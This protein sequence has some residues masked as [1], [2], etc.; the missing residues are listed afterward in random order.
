MPPVDLPLTAEGIWWRY[1][2]GPWVLR[3]L[4]FTVAPGDLLRVRGGNGSGKS[5][6]LALL[7]GVVRPSRGS[8]RTPGRTAYLPQ[9][10][11]NLPPVP[12]D[13]VRALIGGRDGP[14][15]ES[16]AEHLGTRADQLS[17]GTARRVL[18]DAVLS[19]PAPVVVLDEPSAGLDDAAVGRLT[20][21]LAG[22]LADGGIVVVAEHRPLPLPGGTVLDLG[23]RSAAPAGALV[24]ITL[25]GDG[26]TRVVT[27]PPADRDALLRDALDRGWSVL[28]VEPA[29]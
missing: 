5:T 20:R 10:A 23:G 18:L 17:A 24:R 21:A 4:S 28:A 14:D 15:D 13:R 19:L 1:R 25:A 6:L 8:T 22:R 2:R 11:R 7:A 27:V 16:L 12:A 9:L 26:E 29:P 3:D